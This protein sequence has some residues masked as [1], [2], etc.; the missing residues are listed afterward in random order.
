MDINEKYLQT[1]V[2][3]AK[4]AGVTFKKNFGKAKDVQMKDHD[5]RNLVT[6]VDMEIETQIRKVV[7]KKYP[8]HKIIGEEYTQDVVGKD[9]LVW[10]IDP[11]DGTTNYIQ[12]LPFC[13]ISI[14]L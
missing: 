14:A 8:S 9:D 7:T 12:G 2:L 6:E 3:A 5:F 13:C 10:I 1:A 4:N 11:I